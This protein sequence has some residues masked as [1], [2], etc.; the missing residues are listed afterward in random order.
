MKNYCK[1]ETAEDLK[2]KKRHNVWLQG[3][4]NVNVHVTRRDLSA[5]DPNEK[6]LKCHSMHS[7]IIQY[8]YEVTVMLSISSVLLDRQEQTFVLEEVT[9]QVFIGMKLCWD[10]LGL[11]EMHVWLTGVILHPF[12]CIWYSVIKRVRQFMRQLCPVGQLCPGYKNTVC[13]NLSCQ[14]SFW[15]NSK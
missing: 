2:K 8:S 10:T 11:V 14:W 3:K 5:L 15:L 4:Q 12:L 1:T 13:L 6:S 9:S 7:Y